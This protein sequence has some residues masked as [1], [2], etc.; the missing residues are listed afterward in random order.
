MLVMGSL[1]P[2][3]SCKEAGTAVHGTRPRTSR[4]SQ[5]DVVQCRTSERGPDSAV[6]RPSCWHQTQTPRT[7]SG[8]TAWERGPW[9]A[10]DR[11]WTELVLPSEAQ[12]VGIILQWW[13]AS[14]AVAPAPGPRRLAWELAQENGATPGQGW[15]PARVPSLR[16]RDGLSAAAGK[17]GFALGAPSEASLVSPRPRSALGT[18]IR[19]QRL[20]GLMAG[21]VTT[22][23]Q[24]VSAKA[25]RG[26]QF[27]GSQHGSPGPV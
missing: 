15:Q 22:V 16:T 21:A 8:S 1:L 20:A 6:R 9:D 10:P 7:Q 12:D 5:L 14:C 11:K 23:G 4:V 17:E 3:V 13:T 2:T 18:C 19:G 24:E 26:W 27:A 25:G